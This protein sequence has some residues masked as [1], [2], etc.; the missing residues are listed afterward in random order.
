MGPFLGGCRY[1]GPHPS[2]LLLGFEFPTTVFALSRAS[3]QLLQCESF[4]AIPIVLTSLLLFGNIHCDS[5]GKSRGSGHFAVFVIFY[6][7]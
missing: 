6:L 2:A 4:T 5:A 1:I 3:H 7:G